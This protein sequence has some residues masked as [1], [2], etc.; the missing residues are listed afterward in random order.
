MSC[1]QVLRSQGARS[2][3]RMST[4]RKEDRYTDR[5]LVPIVLQP[6]IRLL[7]LQSELR[8]IMYKY[9]YSDSDNLC[10]VNNIRYNYG[11]TPV[12]IHRL[13]QLSSLKPVCRQLRSE[14]AGIRR[15]IERVDDYPRLKQIASYKVA[16]IVWFDGRDSPNIQDLQR[17]IR[18]CE[19]HLQTGWFFFTGR[20]SPKHG[21]LDL[22]A[23][24][25]AYQ[26][27]LRAQAPP[28]LAIM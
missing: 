1:N 9:T 18:Y 3:V 28:L 5:W 17:D 7:R 24:S 21:A 15:H 10:I 27:Y 25:T 6:Q 13:L 26:R 4:L 22:L 12:R 19:Q 23:L 11:V 8:L 2:L 16:K 20:R 14:T